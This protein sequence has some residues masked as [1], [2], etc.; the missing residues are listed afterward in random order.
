[1]HRANKISPLALL[2]MPLLGVTPKVVVGACEGQDNDAKIC[3]TMFFLFDCRLKGNFLAGFI[4]NLLDSFTNHFTV[5]SESALPLSFAHSAI[6]FS[7]LT[8]L[9]VSFQFLIT[10]FIFH[11]S[12]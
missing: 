6:V 1:M 5:I 12:A 7:S 3:T 10:F 2:C 8:V 11:Y 9:T 4:Q